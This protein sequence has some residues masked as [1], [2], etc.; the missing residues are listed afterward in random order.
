MWS[1]VML[2]PLLAG[3]A[4][5]GAVLDNTRLPLDQHGNKLTTGEAG[6]LHHNGAFYLFTAG[7]LKFGGSPLS[8]RHPDPTPTNP[9]P[10]SATWT[11]PPPSRQNDWN[12]G[13]SCPGVDCCASSVGCAGASVGCKAGGT[14][15]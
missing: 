9:T 6:V 13:N 14:S 1:R 2:L 15:L 3:I 10:T 4:A 12:V 7:G 5:T 8:S 11:S